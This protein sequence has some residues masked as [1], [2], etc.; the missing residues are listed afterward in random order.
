MR[1]PTRVVVW[2][3]HLALPLGGLWLLIARPDLDGVWEDHLAHFWLV[4]AVAAI[5][6]LLGARMNAEAQ[7]REDARLL[8]VSLAFLSS[9]GF[10]LLHALATPGLILPHANSGFV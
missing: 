6:V 4:L 2:L 1:S 10:L 5:N 3:F 7:R 8:L 9:A